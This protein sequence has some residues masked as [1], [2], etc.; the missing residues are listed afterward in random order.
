MIK[1]KGRRKKKEE[2]EGRTLRG[3]T[4]ND[5][6]CAISAKVRHRLQIEKDTY[7]GPMPGGLKT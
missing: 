7:G 5:I 2:K 6:Y 3:N 4:G 1:K